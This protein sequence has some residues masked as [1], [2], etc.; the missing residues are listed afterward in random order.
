MRIV[1]MRR[2]FRRRRMVMMVNGHLQVGPAVSVGR[3][4]ACSVKIW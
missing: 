1:M 2:R 3:D 4:V